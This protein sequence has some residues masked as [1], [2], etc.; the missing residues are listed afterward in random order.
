MLKMSG[1]VGR[2]VACLCPHNSTLR[3]CTGLTGVP[4]NF[5]HPEPGNVTLF[6]NTV[7]A[8]CDKTPSLVA[9][10]CL[11]QQVWDRAWEPAFPALPGNAAGGAGTSP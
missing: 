10:E 2:G 5:V 1:W 3:T 9:P 8:R 11:T 4:P 7:F 6:G